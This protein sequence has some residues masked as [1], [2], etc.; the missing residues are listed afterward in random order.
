M[1]IYLSFDL[2]L[3]GDTLHTCIFMLVFLEI[4]GGFSFHKTGGKK[5]FKC[6]FWKCVQMFAYFNRLLNLHVETYN[7]GR[8][9]N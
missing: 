4:E 1:C 2:N 8:S 7:L 3:Q 5:S 6:I 9:D